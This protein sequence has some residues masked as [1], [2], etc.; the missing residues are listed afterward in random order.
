ME[1]GTEDNKKEAW[2][3]LLYS[4]LG[5]VLVI[6]IW[7]II[8]FSTAQ[9]VFPEFFLTLGNMFSLFTD[10]NVFIGLG[11]SILRIIITLAI[12]F[13][14]GTLLGLLSAFYPPLE[15]IMSPLIYLLTALPT[16]SLIFIFI[17]YTKIT[18][19]LLVGV[20]TFPII[21]KA[22]LGGGKIILNRYRLP[23]GLEG[24]YKAKNFFKVLLPLSLPYMSLSLAQASGLALKAEIMGEV[25]MSSNRF[26]GIGVLINSAYLS[27][28]T[29]RLF[30][31]TLLAV[32]FMSLVELGLFFVKR[33]LTNK[34]GIEPTKTFRLI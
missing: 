17:I 27:V 23:I 24:R 34:Y 25:F 13:F 11:Y 26:K 21:Y 9:S 31:L 30:A 28:D 29:Q 12:V 32:L 3:K 10:K 16:A 7:E 14:L 22:V 8:H 18:C 33:A 1:K 4:F 2:F 6:V 19:E 5:I 20:L 15:R